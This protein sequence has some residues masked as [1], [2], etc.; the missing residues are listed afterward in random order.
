MI[1]ASIAIVGIPERWTR[2]GR[3]CG[4]RCS[5]RSSAQRL[6][7]NGMKSG[8]TGSCFERSRTSASG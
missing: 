6:R 1:R 8:W 5:K 3:S 4:L 7:S 2:P